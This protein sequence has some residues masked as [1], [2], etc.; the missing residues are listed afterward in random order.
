M[1]EIVTLKFKKGTTGGSIPTGLTH[2]E[3]AVNTTDG[4]LFVG[5]STGEST[6]LYNRTFIDTTQD[7][8]GTW[9]PNRG[10]RW[11]TGGTGSTEKIWDGSSWVTTDPGRVGITITGATLTGGATVYGGITVFNGLDV[12]SD[13]IFLY[14]DI[15]KGTTGVTLSSGI[16][17]AFHNFAVETKDGYVSIGPLNAGYCHFFTD[18]PEFY[19]DRPLI[20]EYA[21]SA[22]EAQR[23]FHICT[24]P[25]GDGTTA[26]RIT[27]LTGSDSRLG[28]FVGI[29]T[30]TPRAKLDVNGDTIIRG[31][32]DVTGGAIVSNNSNLFGATRIGNGVS[33]TGGMTITGGSNLFG[34]VN[35]KNGLSVTGGATITGGTIDLFGVVDIA[36]GLSVTGGAT[37]KD[38][39]DL[40]GTVSIN[41]GMS[42]ISG[43]MTITG[44]SYLT[45]PTEI[46]NGLSVTGGATMTGGSQFFG[47][48]NING[49]L[50]VSGTIPGGG[51]AVSD[52]VVVQQ[53]YTNIATTT[54]YDINIAGLTAGYTY[55]YVLTYVRSNY[56]TLQYLKVRFSAS[57]TNKFVM[58]RHPFASVRN[59][60]VAGTQP[61]HVWSPGTAGITSTSGLDGSPSTIRYLVNDP[62]KQLRNIGGYYDLGGWGLQGNGTMVVY[63]R[64]EKIA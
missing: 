14:T 23:P 45:G 9:Y 46:S 35:L 26:N 13:D 41:N 24:P 34:T 29:G 58:L 3:L 28:G 18:K 40:F 15:T 32:L 43:G 49:N 36:N 4:V 30:V 53:T 59:P 1:T 33:V 22:Y 39:I 7:P 42:V 57:S 38:G 16:P 37:I 2:G 63:F 31:A 19:F 17:A 48:M 47:N 51:A 44:G 27:V 5:S 56:T 25:S 52:V 60:G 61:S 8:E 10:D 50:T 55:H 54:N 64:V 6:P 21:L 11:W 62:T 20:F 12:A